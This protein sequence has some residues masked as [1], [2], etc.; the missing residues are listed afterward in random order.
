[1]RPADAPG[2]Y[3]SLIIGKERIVLAC[4]GDPPVSMAV[5]LTAFPVTRSSRTL[6]LEI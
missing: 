2:N 3:H 1:M 5:L 6:I 4:V